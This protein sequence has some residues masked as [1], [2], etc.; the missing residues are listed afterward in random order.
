MN[1]WCTSD[2]TLN[3]S[4]I[5]SNTITIHRPTDAFNHWNVRRMQC[6]TTVAMIALTLSSCVFFKT[7]SIWVAESMRGSGLVTS[8]LSPDIQAHLDR[9]GDKCSIQPIQLGQASRRTCRHLANTGTFDLE[10]VTH[11]RTLNYASSALVS[12]IGQSVSHWNKAKG[13]ELIYSLCLLKI[14]MP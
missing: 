12:N 2:H 6:P 7:R 3:R 4:H 8:I 11:T 10:T 13:R 9:Q 14:D 5:S 1:E